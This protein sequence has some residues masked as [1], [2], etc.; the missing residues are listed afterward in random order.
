[1]KEAL[2]F[3]WFNLK[4]YPPAPKIEPGVKKWRLVATFVRTVFHIRDASL[5]Q[6]DSCWQLRG[7]AVKNAFEILSQTKLLT[8][9]SLSSLARYSRVQ[10]VCRLSEKEFGDMVKQCAPSSSDWELEPFQKLLD[11]ILAGP[12][13]TPPES[14]P[15]SKAAPAK[16][17]ITRSAVSLTPSLPLGPS[18]FIIPRGPAR[19]PLFGVGAPRN[20]SATHDEIAAH[21]GLGLAFTR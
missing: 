21:A 8:T 5:G 18:P 2:N 6:K 13:Q 9:P 16:P 19:I 1:V 14:K 15:P 4:H 12:P 17:I 11:A 3:R 7:E 10:R 20:R